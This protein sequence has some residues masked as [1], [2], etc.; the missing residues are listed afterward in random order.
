MN[1][2]ITTKQKRGQNQKSNAMHNRN[3]VQ[4][5]AIEKKD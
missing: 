4:M 3:A 5:N 2:L 1:I